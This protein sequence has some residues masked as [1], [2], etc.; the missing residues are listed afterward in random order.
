MRPEDRE[1]IQLEVTSRLLERHTAL[2]ETRNNYLET[3]VGDTIYHER[4]RLERDRPKGDELA[5]YANLGKRLPKASEAEI[6]RML[7]SLLRRFVAEVVGNFDERVYRFST[8][9]VPAGLSLLLTASGARGPRDLLHLRDITSSVR[10]HIEV[11]GEV[12]HLKHLIKR[13]TVM[14]VPTHSSHLDS[15]VLGYAAHLLELPPLLYGA[16]LNLF[17]NPLVSFFMNNLG[18]YR[19][20]RKKTC[21]V[22]K[23]VLK[24]YA[25]VAM[26]MGYHNLF[27]PGGTRSRSG[28]V[29]SKLKKGLL[30]TAVSAYINNLKQGRA[31]PNVYV[32]P[33]TISYSL[34]LEAETLIDDYL[35]EV[36]KSRYIIED[37]EF[38][39]PRRVL[40]FMNEIAS[41]DGRIVVTLS[42]P[43]DIVGNFVDDQGNSLDPRGRVVDTKAYVS[44]HGA[45]KHDPQ[46]DQQYTQE[47]AESVVRGLRRDSVVMTTN[48]VALALLNLLVR[49]NPS[50]DRYRLL[51]TGGTAPSFTHAD[52]VTETGRVKQ[53]IERLGAPRL[54]KE[55]RRGT[56]LTIVDD[57]LRR[58][59]TY[60]SRPVAERRGDRIFHEDRNLL[61]YYSNRLQ[62][63]DLE[64]AGGA[65]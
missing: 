9:V 11:Q 38:S 20:D 7:E 25:S 37:D 32:V 62:G 17:T 42:R 58:F 14:V 18:A 30:G 33:C 60:H 23:D 27:F 48:V 51:R 44:R 29:E 6:A 39:K 55:I 22:Y 19:V 59:Q 57:A 45:P 21:A 24:E 47:I 35:K 31:Q 12:Q 63:Y 61:F 52:V 8:S 5:F 26:E 36:G 49:K 13:G 53:Q 64:R 2:S 41:L 40:N 65:Q 43:L 1:R 46:R 34:V 10:D 15:I 3:L 54:S 50:L 4:R 16:G 28:A 56:P